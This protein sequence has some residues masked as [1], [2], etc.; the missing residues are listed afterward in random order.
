LRAWQRLAL[1]PIAFAAFHRSDDPVAFAQARLIVL[2]VGQGLSTVVDTSAHRLLYDA[3]P[4]YPSGFDLGDA[5]VVPALR[6]TGAAQLDLLVVSHGDVDHR[7]GVPAVERRTIT[8]A[9]LSAT[10]KVRGIPCRRGTA[11]QWDGVVFEVLNPAAAAKEGNDASC[12]LSIRA[13]GGAALLPGDIGARAESELVARHAPLAAALL[14]VPHHGSKTSS[15]A[16]F[17][18]AVQPSVAV[19]SAGYRNRFGHPH[20]DVVARYAQYGIDFATT[21]ERGALVWDS[22]RPAELRAIVSDRPRW[23]AA[24]NPDDG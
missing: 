22:A 10:S 4:R 18:A 3:G 23:L 24:A 20:P 13:A 14:V 5:V 7:G 16:A 9:V 17:L 21:V 12:V 11:W 15:T 2:D 8:R 1:V 6:A 19:A